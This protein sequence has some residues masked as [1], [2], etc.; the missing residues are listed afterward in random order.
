MLFLYLFHLAKLKYNKFW[1]HTIQVKWHNGPKRGPWNQGLEEEEE[2]TLAPEQ[3]TMPD[4]IPGPLTPMPDVIPGPPSGPPSPKEINEAETE[5][6]EEEDIMGSILKEI[7]E[8]Q[9]RQDKPNG[10]EE[11]LN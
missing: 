9:E 3:N 11:D 4:V 6:E 2:E 1:R 8:D 7:L 5:E 10:D